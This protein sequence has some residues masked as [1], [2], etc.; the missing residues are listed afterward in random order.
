MG[1]FNRLKRVLSEALEPVPQSGAKRY[2]I[3]HK[4]GTTILADHVRKV[5]SPNGGRVV[6]VVGI[7][8]VSPTKTNGTPLNRK[9]LTHR[10]R[11]FFKYIGQMNARSVARLSNDYLDMQNV[12]G[13]PED[14]VAPL[15]RHVLVI[16]ANNV[17]SVTDNSAPVQPVVPQN[18]ANEI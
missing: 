18:P 11:D 12:G 15:F 14:F 10:L 5:R 8:P 13:R 1:F 9:G 4:K 3:A 16:G 17:A 2:S 7:D 6:Y